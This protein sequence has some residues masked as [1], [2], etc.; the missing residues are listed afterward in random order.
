METIEF[1]HQIRLLEL[2][3][4]IAEMQ[5]LENLSNPVTIL[6][7][8]SG[9][10]QQAKLLA[11][12]GYKVIA[13][14]IPSSAYKHQRIYPILE[15]DGRHIP[16]ENSTID[17]VFSSN[18]LEHISDIDDFLEEIKRV[19][20]PNGHAI[21]ILPSSSWRFWSNIFHYGWLTKKAF[22]IFFKKYKTEKNTRNEKKTSNLLKTLFPSRHGERGNAVTEIYFYST[23]WWIKKF[24]Q[25]EFTIKKIKNNNLAY[26]NSFVFKKLIPIKYRVIISYLLGSS[27]KIYI[28]KKKSS[29]V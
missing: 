17:I 25:K 12:H 28:M 11:E 15:Y 27:C 6:E 16:C 14:D 4:A 22:S 2:E 13:L 7:I 26:T 20:T 3:S 8:G 24:H 29:D 21:H 19:L 9:T 23:Y 18:V 1:L 10:G 5:Q